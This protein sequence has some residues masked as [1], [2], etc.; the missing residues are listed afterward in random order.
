MQAGA[1]Q[2][3]TLFYGSRLIELKDCVF[4]ENGMVAEANVEGDQSMGV[5]LALDG[6]EPLVCLNGLD[7]CTAGL[8][9]CAE[10]LDDTAEHVQDAGLLEQLCDAAPCVKTDQGLLIGGA[11]WWLGTTIFNVPESVMAMDSPLLSDVCPVDCA[12]LGE[13]LIQV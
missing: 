9:T 13:D 2:T 10:F 1:I 12:A 8:F 7:G 4:D 11:D 6:P 3:D 5:G